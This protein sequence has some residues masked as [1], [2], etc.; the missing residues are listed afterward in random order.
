M[1][2]VNIRNQKSVRRINR[3]VKIV[4]SYFSSR[5]RHTRC[6]L[7][8]GVQTCALPIFQEERT[9]F[10]GLALLGVTSPLKVERATLRYTSAVGYDLKSRT[11]IDQKIG[12]ASCRE[13]VYPYV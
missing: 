12:I 4:N 2:E 13:M 5:R 6:E 10:G 3:R 7:V 9:L 11:T 8:T 1:R